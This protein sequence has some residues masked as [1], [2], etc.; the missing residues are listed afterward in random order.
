MLKALS[1]FW[2]S[3]FWLYFLSLVLL[4]GQSRR[5]KFLQVTSAQFW[6]QKKM[7]CLNCI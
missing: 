2:T 4:K 1:V 6:A 7:L 3:S 5:E